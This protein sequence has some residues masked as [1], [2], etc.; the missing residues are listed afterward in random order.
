MSLFFNVHEYYGCRFSQKMSADFNITVES[1]AIAA[2]VASSAS[3]LATICCVS[4]QFITFHIVVVVGCKQQKNGNN[5]LV[6]ATMENFRKSILLFTGNCAH[7]WENRRNNERVVSINRH[8]H[9]YT[10]TIHIIESTWIAFY[11]YIND[12]DWI[13]L[14]SEG[15]I[16]CVRN[17]DSVCIYFAWERKIDDI[18]SITH[19]KT[20]KIKRK[21][22]R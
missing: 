12:Q 20:L 15:I 5:V 9:I 22:S 4:M 14:R 13:L 16:P 8:I 10:Y 21:S 11:R 2:A 3:T 7:E 19:G 18:Q 1:V 6:N 17:S